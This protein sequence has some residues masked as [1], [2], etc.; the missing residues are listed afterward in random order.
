ML[1]NVMLLSQG[2]LKT[3]EARRKS[4]FGAMSAMTRA[5]TAF[6]EF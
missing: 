4:A 5:G 2:E 1:F 3:N 6:A